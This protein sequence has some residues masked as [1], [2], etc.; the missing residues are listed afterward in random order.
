MTE[1]NSE[2]G[3][4]ILK[5][6]KTAIWYDRK[7][8]RK[9][10]RCSKTGTAG[11]NVPVNPHGKPV[12]AEKR[13]HSLRPLP[14]MSSK[15]PPVKPAA[16]CERTSVTVM[17]TQNS[18]PQS[19]MPCPGTALSTSGHAHRSSRPLKSHP[20]SPQLFASGLPQVFAPGR[21]PEGFAQQNAGV[22]T[23]DWSE[24]ICC[25]LLY[26]FLCFF[27]ILIPIS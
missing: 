18:S 4:V 11:G 17:R 23:E 1:M 5:T 24:Q 3:F 7:S 9:A 27:D 13:V 8:A 22:K 16:V 2:C 25:G 21:A 15:P 6:S 19:S 20:S 14:S 26:V 10:G 12:G